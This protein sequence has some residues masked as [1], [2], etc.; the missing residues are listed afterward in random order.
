MG[1]YFHSAYM[2][3]G[4][5]GSVGGLFTLEACLLHAYTN[6]FRHCLYTSPPQYIFVL[7][8][9]SYFSCSMLRV[10]IAVTTIKWE[11]FAI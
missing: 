9:S 10:A 8:H 2:D 3:F 5:M 6:T 4:L 11:V 1:D 7:V